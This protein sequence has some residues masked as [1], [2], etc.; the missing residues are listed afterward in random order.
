MAL[1]TS[2]VALS[3]DIMLPAL[4]TIGEDLGVA[5]ANDAQLVIRA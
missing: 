3:T 4:A 5:R 2:L 1:M